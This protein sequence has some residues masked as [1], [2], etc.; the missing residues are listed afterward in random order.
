MKYS[1]GCCD[2]G[3]F[4]LTRYYVICTSKYCFM[5]VGLQC[6]YLMDLKQGYNKGLKTPKEKRACNCHSIVCTWQD[7]HQIVV[8][9]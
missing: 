9:N 4:Q 3:R 1:L 8:C 5:V 6:K 2:S 7:S